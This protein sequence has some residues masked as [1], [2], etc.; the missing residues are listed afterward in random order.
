MYRLAILK[1]VRE[2]SVNLAYVQG[3][4]L[5]VRDNV[6][7]VDYSHL[8]EDN[9][10]GSFG[11]SRLL[12]IDK[13]GSP[14][15]ITSHSS[16]FIVSNRSILTRD[17]REPIPLFFKYD[18]GR[19]THR[20]IATGATTDRDPR[21]VIRDS[22]RLL[23]RFGRPLDGFLWD[24]SATLFNL[25]REEY[26]VTIYAHA[27]ARNDTVRVNY[28]SRRAS[29]GVIGTRTEVVNFAPILQTGVD[30]L[31]STPT[32][33]INTPGSGPSSHAAPI[34]GLLYLGPDG[35]GT[36]EFTSGTSL[37]LTD[38]TT[39]AVVH[40]LT[41]TDT[42]RE[43]VSK[44]NDT[45]NGRFVAVPMADGLV[46]SLVATTASTAVD[47]FGVFVLAS[48]HVRIRLNSELRMQAL[49]PYDD[50]PS[51]PWWPRITKGEFSVDIAR[52]AATK[53]GY[54][55]VPADDDTN[56]LA[57]T[58]RYSVPE[59]EW[60]A[61]SSLHPERS[62]DGYRYMDRKD[63]QPRR[64]SETVLKLARQRVKR[65]SVKVFLDG[66]EQTTLVFDVDEHG[67]VIFLDTPHPR[68]TA[69]TVDYAYEERTFLYK[70]I[71]LNPGN[72]Y[73]KVDPDDPTKSLQ[74]LGNYVGVYAMP[75]EVQVTDG[76]PATATFTR[77][78]RHVVTDDIRKL[79]GRASSLFP[80]VGLGHGGLDS[81]ASWDPHP[82]LLGVYEV[83]RSSNQVLVADTR[84]VG[85]G[86]NEEV[87]GG[88]PL[89]VNGALVMEFPEEILGTGEPPYHLNAPTTVSGWYKPFD[90][91]GVMTEEDVLSKVR[92]YAAA[93][94]E[95]LLDP[96]DFL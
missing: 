6:S 94:V 25:A 68:V 1:K 12:A 81:E 80:G 41:G 74:V 44:I 59:Y 58:Q 73:G 8:E 93:G 30:I 48:G 36:Y 62:P 90:P 40:T 55:G 28:R 89:S 61:F 53:A 86:A 60:Q 10:T 15:A 51:R 79:I 78:I 7:L 83:G 35:S 63:E 88:R 65:T 50:P 23:D 92:R 56:H 45:E 27:R 39:G 3:E 77:S 18:I 38:T 71:D 33:T 2:G 54:V 95:V 24:V 72:P 75:T 31:G 82:V 43:A 9:L 76:T 67:G 13:S 91:T 21:A 85:G 32:F 19:S 29:D 46:S 42:I 57:G 26:D 17:T 49:K 96:T 64:L 84:Q 22:I 20:V 34:I 70:G 11:S 37:T 87:Y 47:Q 5:T 16:D 66:N 52:L 4:N 14:W 69:L